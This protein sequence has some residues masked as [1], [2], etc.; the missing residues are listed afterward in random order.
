[1]FISYYTDAMNKSKISGIYAIKNKIN[2]KRYVG[3]SISVHYRWGQQHRPELRKQK[4]RNRH[5]QRAWNKYGEDAFEFEVIEACEVEHLVEREGWWIEHTQ[6]WDRNHGYNLSRIVQ[7][8]RVLSEETLALMRGPWD[9][10]LELH[11]QGLG[12]N[13]IAEQLKVCRGT[14]YR[15]LEHHGLHTNEG[16]GSIVKLTAEMKQDI[17]A[18]RDEGMTWEDILRETGISKTQVYRTKVAGD[19]KYGGDKVKRNGYRTM[20]PEIKEEAIKLRSTGMTWEE[21]GKRFGISRQQFYWHGMA[22]LQQNAVRKTVTSESIEEAAKL[23][24]QG[25]SWKAIGKQLGYS[26][27][28]FKR[29]IQS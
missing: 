12:R 3:S 18:L 24:K 20:T 9:K 22:E 7:G 23:R 1:M 5:L 11:N 16:K 13:T 17:M 15:C 8:R 19:G 2:G 29:Y 4:H 25:L 6:S 26:E 27:S 28:S 14:V 10:I 21:I